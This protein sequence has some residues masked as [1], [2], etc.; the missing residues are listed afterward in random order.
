MLL[1]NTPQKR[2]EYREELL[3]ILDRA[4]LLDAKAMRQITALVREMQHEVNDRLSFELGRLLRGEGGSWGVYWLPRLQAA[5]AD[6]VREIGQ[7]TA[8]ELSGHLADSYALGAE[9][10]D[11]GLSVAKGL[12][13]TSPVIT[14]RTLSVI[15]PFSAKLIVAITDSTRETIDKAIRRTVA[16]GEAPDKLMQKLQGHIGTEGTPFRTVAQ[17]AEVIARTELSRVQNLASEARVRSI[18]QEFPEVV[19][20][21]NGL[22]QQYVSVQR[23]PWPCKICA[24]DHGRIFEINDATKPEIPRHPNCRCMYATY[25]PGVSTIVEP[26]VRRQEKA[27]LTTDSRGNPRAPTPRADLQ[28]PRR[29]TE[30][31]QHGCTCSHH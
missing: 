2:A 26:I 13:V 10:V 6:V 29:T 8:E 27:S 15:A 11:T 7:R 14:A 18:V 16:L 24:P 28:R 22:K 19:L 25:F 1:E 9:I 3:A 30:A 17:R 23:G 21:D 12:Q 5:I 31:H 4:D 20:T